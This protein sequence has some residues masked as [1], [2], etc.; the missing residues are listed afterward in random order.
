[1]HVL[2]IWSLTGILHLTTNENVL[3]GPVQAELVCAGKPDSAHQ[4]SSRCKIGYV[5]RLNKNSCKNIGQTTC[6]R[7]T[8]EGQYEQQASE[9]QQQLSAPSVSK[10]DA[11]RSPAHCT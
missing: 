7:S 6:V 8:Q 11:F 1:M 10:Q 5:I 9:Q 2:S 3:T 4:S